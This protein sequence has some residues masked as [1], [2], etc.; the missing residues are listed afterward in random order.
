MQKLT[1]NLALITPLIFVVMYI[2]PL[3]LR[4]LWSPDEIRYAEIARE[5]VS[6]GNWTV[7]TFNGLRYFEKPVM[8]HWMNAVS[9]LLFGENNFSV[10]AASV[11]SS[12]GSALCLWLLVERFITRQMAWISTSIFISLFMVAA[13][14]TYSVL[15][16]MFSL[17]LT[18]AF[19]AFFFAFTADNSAGR[20]KN[21][22]LAGLFCG[23][24]FLTKGFL[25]LLLP[26][27]VVF[28]FLLW[29]KQFTSIL[30]WGWWVIAI[31]LLVC[32]PWGVAIHLAEPDFWFYFFWVEHIQRFAATNA[33]HSEPFWYYFA[34]LPLAILPWL[35]VAPT[36]IRHLGK[37]LN[38]PLIRYALLWAVIPILFFSLARG[39]IVTYILPSMVPLA[40]LLAVG[41][42][43]AYQ[44]QTR[45]F[46]WGSVVNAIVMALIASAFLILY[47]LGYLPLEQG[48]HYRPWLAF[49]AFSFWALFACLA[50][51]TTTLEAKIC[52]YSMMPVGLFL[53]FWA[54][55][56]NLSIN[57]KM[58]AAFIEELK[59]YVTEKTI[60]L[61]D[62]PS[63]MSALNWYLQRNDVYLL[64]SKGE[65]EYGLS[66]P[67]A[68][69]RFITQQQL[70][71]FIKTKQNNST[72][73]IFMRGSALPETQ[74]PGISKRFQRGRFSAYY[75]AKD[76]SHD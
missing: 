18:A 21:Y 9:Q 15:D 52:C 58:P 8:G 53:F 57:S 62:H 50:I 71:E 12:A 74:L 13:I 5:M 27:I 32:L 40:I 45:G 10:R 34:Y 75:F 2:I 26:V 54:S 46:K 65:L 49:T 67:D 16:S 59:P 69:D 20:Y 47:Y 7:P 73:L 51:R 25:A 3:G 19:S 66:Y 68:A 48:E 31:A 43:S 29:Q 38:L 28:P 72:L 1:I 4:D 64:N 44:K 17:W 30:R 24:A 61:A 6:S 11:F 56:P 60:L 41:L 70:A 37:H 39:K 42:S 23:L 22:G 36:A 14:G 35:F 63:T 33:Q 55:I 76:T